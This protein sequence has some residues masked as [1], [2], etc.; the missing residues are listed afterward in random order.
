MPRGADDRF[1]Q[2]QGLPSVFKH[3]LLD[4]YVPQFAG[5]T[6]SRSTARKV[7]FLDGYAGRGR[8]GD[9][10]P[11]SAEL[12]LRMAQNQGN[13]GTVAWTCFFVEVDDDDAALLAAVVDEYARQGVHATAHH[14]SVLDV[15]DDVVQAALGCPLFVFLDPCGLGIPYD[16]LTALLRQERRA[17]WPPTEVLLN[18][19]LEAV[20]RISGHVGS[21]RG[22]EAT[23]AR[24]D[25]T[26][27]G[28][29]W[30][31]E[32]SDEGVTD[33][34][35]E[36]VVR[37]FVN[38][39]AHDTGMHILSV[40]VRRAPR[41]KPVYHLVFGTRAQHGLWAFGDS[42]AQATEAWWATLEERTIEQEPG[43]LFPVTQVERPSLETIKSKALAEIELNLEL[44]LR[45]YPW[46]KVVD[47][48]TRVFGSYYGQVRE[49]LVRQA[50]KNMHR[51]GR[52][53]SDGVG[54]RIR[55]LIVA[56]PQAE[57]ARRSGIP[58]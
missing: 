14:G 40:P 20:R 57:T 18:F 56:R 33:Q 11:A 23:R 29:W 12:V 37:R 9:G 42:T 47:H 2:E 28:N 25:Q 24:L 54:R 39:L 5:M 46:F 3:T 51:D 58:S 35:V 27:G 45:D 22:S 7:V 16:R 38:Q 1:W 36:T 53:S 30:R 41:Q 32:F 26:L 43:T 15:L 19:S 6:G 21:E 44:L 34:A 13:A 52:T 17:Q 49:T 50:I 4:K 48:T 55:E 10:R 31:S 8:Y